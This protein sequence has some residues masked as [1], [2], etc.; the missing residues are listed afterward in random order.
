MDNFG[1]QLKNL[2]I[3]YGMTQADLAKLSDLGQSTISALETG[4][5]GPWPSTRRALAHAFQMSL[6]EFDAVTLDAAPIPRRSGEHE[7][8]AESGWQQG[9]PRYG[10]PLEAAQNSGSAAPGP[11]GGAFLP[12]SATGYP[13]AQSK[14]ME[15]LEE[16]G[17]TE[18]KLKQYEQLVRSLCEASW[19][20]DA[21]LQITGAWGRAA[22]QV[23][24][25]L[26]DLTGRRVRDFLDQAFGGGGPGSPL[27]AMHQRAAKGA[28]VGATWEGQGRQFVICVDPARDQS[29]T[30]IGTVGLAVD[31]THRQTGPS[32]R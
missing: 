2:R 19:T 17:E 15:L 20:T 29:G 32:P 23:R 21:A 16:L 9:E 22:E 4:R 11:P 1:A 25:R 7:P 27:V 6:E 10:P 14:V 26:G 3:R 28:S 8:P 5:Q 30:I 18:H 12:E 24:S 31:M 13:F